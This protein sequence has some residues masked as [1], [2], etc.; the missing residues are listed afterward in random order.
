MSTEKNIE[1]LESIEV[2]GKKKWL[3]QEETSDTGEI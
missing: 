1:Q 2:K 3:R